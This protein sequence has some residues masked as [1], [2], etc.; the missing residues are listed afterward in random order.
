MKQSKYLP[1]SYFI[2][3]FISSIVSSLLIPI[4]TILNTP[5][6]YSGMVFIIFGIILNVWSDSIF[7]LRKTTVKPFEKSFFLITDGPYHISRHPMYLGFVSILLG[8]SIIL[9]KLS[10]FLF[11]V[12]MVITLEKKFIPYEEKNLERSFGKKYLTYKHRVRRWI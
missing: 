10:A 5:I 7:K 11:P 3:Y 9:G 8:T 6:T 1:P 12:L 2:I 4:S